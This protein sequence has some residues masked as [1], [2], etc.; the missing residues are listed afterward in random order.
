MM[1]KK[2]KR[3]GHYCWCCER[4]RPNE[5]FSGSGHARHLC[6]DCSKL[7]A[8]ELQHRQDRRNLENL[9]TWEGIIGRKQRKTFNRFLEHPDQRIRRYAEEL[10]VRDA[11]V[12]ALPGFFEEES[13][14]KPEDDCYKIEDAEAGESP[15]NLCEQIEITGSVDDGIPF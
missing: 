7:G 2:R 5:K 6:R 9:V 13:F 14:C 1:V 8:A 4:M 12:R 11:E 3:P 10:A 15:E